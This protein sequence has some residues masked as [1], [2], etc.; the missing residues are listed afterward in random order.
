MSFFYGMV[1]NL[2]WFWLSDN[3]GRK[4]MFIILHVLTVLGLAISLL[5]TSLEMVF[6]GFFISGFGGTGSCRFTFVIL[7]EIVNNN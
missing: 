1:L 3:F 5:S 2:L 4:R 6:I 7:S